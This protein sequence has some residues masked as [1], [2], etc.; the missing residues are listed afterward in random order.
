MPSVSRDE[1][2]LAE[3]VVDS[4][5]RGAFL[6]RHA[7]GEGFFYA[8]ERRP[9]SPLVL[10]AGHLDTIPA[11]DNLP[12]R[13]EDGWVVGLGATDMKG[14]LAVMLEL[15]RWL[16][17]DRPDREL[18]V[19]LLFFTREELPVDESPLP[20]GLRG[21][22]RPARG[23]SRHRAR[24]DG[25][26]DPGRLPRQPQCDAHVPRRQRPLG[27]TVARRQRDRRRGRRAAPAHPHPAGAGRHRR[28]DV[29]RGARA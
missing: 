13:I 15:A 4:V 10:L 17:R 19:G 7:D 20:G 24:A 28:S 21:L 14:G 27:A 18:D 12:G 2:R 29:R 25:Q 23:R 26:H 8:T 16:D 22:S 11:Q 1:A 5:P 6:E 9:G 3:L